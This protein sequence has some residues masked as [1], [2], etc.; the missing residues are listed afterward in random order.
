VLTKR[1]SCPDGVNTATN[2]ACCALYPILE[3]IQANLFDGGECGEEVHDLV[4]WYGSCSLLILGKVHESVRLSF[5]DAIGFSRTK[6][7]GGTDGS[8]M[9]FSEIET[10][11]HA[12]NGVQGIIEA[13]KPFVAKHNITAGDL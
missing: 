10:A 7:G 6:G 12:N 11:Y 4:R 9:T 2:A 8:I 3:D 5:H 1:V 13:Q